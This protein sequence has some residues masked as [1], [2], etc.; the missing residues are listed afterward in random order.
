MMDKQEEELRIF[1]M[2]K[3]DIP[4]LSHLELVSHNDR[5]DFVL[6]DKNNG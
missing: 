6:K 4:F 5:P 2:A 3:Q 1:N